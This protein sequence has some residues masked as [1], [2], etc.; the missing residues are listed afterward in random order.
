MTAI[1]LQGIAC[2][3]IVTLEGRSVPRAPRV[4][5]LRCHRPIPSCGS[6][7]RHSNRG[8]ASPRRQLHQAGARSSSSG[9]QPP[10]DVYATGIAGM[11]YARI[12]GPYMLQLDLSRIDSAVLQR[13]CEDGCPESGTL[14]FKRDLPGV[15]DKDKQELL[16]DVCGMAN[17]EG[18]DLVYGVDE[19]SGVAN[20]L[21][22]IAGELA[23][24][25]RRRIL[26]V[27]DAGL[28]PRVQGL[29]VHEVGVT[30]GYALIV[31]VPSS[32]DGPHSARINTNLRRFVM[33]NGT[34]TS[35]MTFDQIRAAFDRTATLAERARNFVA[36]RQRVIGER[37]GAARILPGPICVA[38]L[39]PIAGL[40]GRHSVDLQQVHSS[41]FT[42]FMGDG[43]GGASRTFN[44]DGL[45]I[46]PGAKRDDGYYGYTQIFRT[47]AM[48]S[49]FLAGAERQYGQNEPAKKV[50][51]S[52]DMVKFFRNNVSKFLS[53][54]NDWGFAG[55]AV[56]GFALLG[57]DG[58]ELGVA[59]V[60]RMFNRA[61]ADRSNLVLPEVWLQDVSNVAVDDVV[62]PLMDVMWQAFDL[63][64]CNEFDA[65]TGAYNPR[66]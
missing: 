59:D 51:W 14:D 57:V 6:A 35:D 30:G 21:A 19:T 3:F 61:A 47:G 42:Q 28:D 38:H 34:S 46:H 32:F 23:D 58:Y 53:A 12:G 45:L 10:E 65:S 4:A 40:A 5:W 33:R 11:L 50:V 56:L 20:S 27:L 13:L 1:A 54:A 18:G 37:V 2:I 62:R 26:Q 24:A 44:L 9:R 66:H 17:A 48:E 55:P 7:V 49:A 63:P 31:R 60:F 41:S 39:V 8:W 36:E 29:R 64:R 15:S 16:K 43:W 22:P 52:S 25:A